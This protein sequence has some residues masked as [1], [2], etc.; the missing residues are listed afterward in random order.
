MTSSSGDLRATR[1]ELQQKVQKQVRRMK[2]AEI[3]HKSVLRQT[4]YLGTVGVMFVLPI[5]GGAYLG[6]WLDSL[7]PHYQAHWTVCGIVLGV[8]VGAVNVYFFIKE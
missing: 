4:L 1:Q 8:I 5:V 7:S 6:L 2:R 3:E